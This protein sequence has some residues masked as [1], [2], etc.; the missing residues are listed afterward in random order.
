MRFEWTLPMMRDAIQK[1][2]SVYFPVELPT[3]GIDFNCGTRI[4]LSDLKKRQT[5]S[6]T[7]GL[8]KRLARRFSIIG[9][10]H[11]FTIK[12][13]GESIKPNDR[14]YY[15][16]LQYMW[17]YGDQSDVE[18]LCTNVAETKPRANEFHGDIRSVT[19]W[20]GTVKES[21]QL[22]DELGENLNRIAIFVRGKMA[23]EDILGD[24]TERGVYASYPHRRNS[25]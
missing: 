21:S 13:N 11:D 16:K 4:T 15:D 5:I 17:T 14:G 1:D 7:Q 6:T 25:C 20:L 9:P 2:E 23:Q 24:F 3:S 22:Q 19:G 10:A 8:R 12:V 18:P